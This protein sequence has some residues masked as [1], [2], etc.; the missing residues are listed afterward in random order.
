MY[1]SGVVSEKEM[2]D[3][4]RIVNKYLVEYVSQSKKDIQGSDFATLID[5]MH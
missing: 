3:L 5:Q 4:H 1:Q 2:A